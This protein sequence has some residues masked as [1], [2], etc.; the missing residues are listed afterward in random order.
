MS[1][2]FPSSPSSCLEVSN[3][4]H[5][6]DPQEFPIVNRLNSCK[7]TRQLKQIHSFI[8][9]TT[10]TPLSKITLSMR[11]ISSAIFIPFSPKFPIQVLV[12]TIP[13]SGT[14]RAA[15][16]RTAHSELL[17]KG[18]IPDK[19]TYPFL[20]KA[21]TKSRA[22]REGQEVHARV[23]KNGFVLDLYV[24]STLIRL[25][26][27]CGAIDSAQKMFDEG[28]HMDLV[29]QTTLIQGYVKMGYWKEGPADEGRKHFSEMS[30][31]YNLESQ[32]EHYGCM[33]D[34]LGRAGLV[35]EAQEFIS[36]MPIEPDAFVWGALLGACRIHGNVELGEIIMEKLENLDLERDGT[37]VLMS[38]IYFSA[39]KR[40][41]ALKLRKAMKKGQ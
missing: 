37:Y 31:V 20:L 38:N 7:S 28:P 8:I 2:S 41:N 26:A 4:S 36:N 17:A 1:F 13:L 18:L 35:N 34:L 19:Y 15:R 33:V 25:Y 6:L 3:A 12:C 22:L 40:R 11:Q 5:L 29:S 30:R 16:T 39:N 24:V 32:M 9:K 10:P 14:F 23:V 21:C 27:V